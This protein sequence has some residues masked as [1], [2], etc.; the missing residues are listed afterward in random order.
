M[1]RTFA[2]L[3]LAAALATSAHAA[4]TLRASALVENDV[5]T[6]GDLIDDAGGLAA[7]PLFR[8]P[9]LGQTGDV[10]ATAV[11]EAARRAGLAGIAPSSLAS[12][13]VTRASRD[14]PVSE[15]QALLTARAA[16]EYGADV[17]AIEL[18]IDDARPLRLE[19]SA[20]G[21]VT[22]G[23]FVAD[24]SSGRFEAVLEVAGRPAGGPPLRIAGE[25]VETVEAATLARALARGDILSASD[26]RTER[27]PKARNA[28]VSAPADVL[29]MALRRPMREGQPLRAADLTR[30]QHVERG[31]FVTLIYSG[32]GVTLSLKAKALAAGAAGDVVPVQNIQSKRVVNGVVTGPSEVTV[33]AAP[34]TI[35]R[36]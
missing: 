21:A 34:T 31:A 17:D 35:V 29:G 28:D 4:P 19:A 32:E 22:V 16:T 30:P 26:V 33:S 10:P 27:L 8:A 11:I 5:V 1:T 13:A 14:V 23:R 3:G 25:A 6:V 36:R 15:I 12:V 24:R 2:A 18:A 20:R 9:D 7:A